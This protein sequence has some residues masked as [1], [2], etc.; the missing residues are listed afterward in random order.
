M[1]Y[2]QYSVVRLK[3]IK[4]QFNKTELAIGRREPKVG[5]VATIVEVY[6]KPVIGYELECADPNGVTEWLV[7]FSTE[8]AEFELIKENL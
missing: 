2:K 5:D 7:A 1:K 4:K 8:E 6:E 3:E